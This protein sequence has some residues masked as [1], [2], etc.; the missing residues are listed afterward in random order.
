MY[1]FF[2]YFC[3]N[4]KVNGYVCLFRTTACLLQMFECLHK[5]VQLQLEKYVGRLNYSKH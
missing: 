4:I 2:N 1:I 5:K 3:Y